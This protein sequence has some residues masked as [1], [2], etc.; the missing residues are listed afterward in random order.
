M[1]VVLSWTDSKVYTQILQL[2]VFAYVNEDVGF[3]KAEM[4][5]SH[6]CQFL[7]FPLILPQ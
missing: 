1:H 6:P 3:I 2:C 5:L 4:I 7:F